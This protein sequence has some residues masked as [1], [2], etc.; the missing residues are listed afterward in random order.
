MEKNILE[1]L[2]SQKSLERVVETKFHDM[3]VKV[4]ELKTIFK[5]L[6]CE[7]DSVEIPCSHEE[8]EDDDDDDEEESPPPTTTQFSIR[9]RS[10]VVPA[11]ET[12]QTSS[13]QAS[14]PSASS[15]AQAPSESTPPAPGHSAES[16]ADTLVLTPS[17]VA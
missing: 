17:S 16:F 8:D 10:A 15:P 11:H 3:D 1:I 9:A 13:T 7:V 2:Q 12:R 4:S 5:Q 6:Q 14:T